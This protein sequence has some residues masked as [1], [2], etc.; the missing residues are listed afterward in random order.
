MSGCSELFQPAFK[1]NGTHF[2]GQGKSLLSV[3]GAS[4]N[5]T[6]VLGGG[7][8]RMYQGTKNLPLTIRG[9]LYP[10]KYI[11]FQPFDSLLL[12]PNM[13]KTCVTLPRSK[14]PTSINFRWSR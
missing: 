8:S 1:A 4:I 12:P 3:A 11:L 5:G 9:R 2:S 10:G 6:V 7:P 13:T 14:K